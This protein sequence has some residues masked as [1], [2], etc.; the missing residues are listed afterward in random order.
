MRN[1]AQLDLLETLKGVRLK[2]GATL[3]KALDDLI[4]VH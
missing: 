4:S 2:A 3:G 1:K